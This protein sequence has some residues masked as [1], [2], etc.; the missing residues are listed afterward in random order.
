MTTLFMASAR[1]FAGVVS[2]FDSRRPKIVPLT[3]SM[4]MLAVGAA[5]IV[6]L[7]VG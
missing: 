1:F 6:E 4:V 5:R 2:S 7:P 3:M